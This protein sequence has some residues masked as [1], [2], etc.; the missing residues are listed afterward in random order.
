MLAGT[1][2]RGDACRA[3]IGFDI[4]GNIPAG[5]TIT[6][7]QLSLVLALVP[8]GDA[9]ARPIELHQV[10][11]NWG[12]GTSGQ[13][14]GPNGIGVGFMTPADGTTA[15]WS[16]RF[17]DTVPWANPG[18]EFAAAASS[19]ALVDAG[20]N[21]IFTWNS[22]QALVDDVQGWL[23]NPSSNFGWLLLGDESAAATGR[24]FYTRETSSSVVSPSLVVTYTPPAPTAV[25]LVLSAPASITA[26]SP[27]DV[28]VTVQDN[29]GIVI[30]GYTGTVS[31][32]SS[33]A[34]PAVLPAN[35]TFTS[36]DQGAH[37]FTAGV[38]LFAAGS[39]MLTVQDTANSATTGSAITAVIAAP[40]SQLL[41]T[42]PSIPPSGSP[43]DVTLAA[44]DSFGN[45]DMNYAGTV[46]WTSSDPD[47][48]VVLPANY[49]LQ[50]T[51]NGAVTF[52]SGITLI[53]LGDQTITATD[54]ASGITGSATVTVGPGA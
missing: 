31:F 50:S 18:G 10:L 41:V 38:T 13:D 32:S 6:S 42:A 19:T 44:I 9:V 14:T 28:T 17:Y 53:T 7:V 8:M 40:A 15:T 51:D 37:T 3:L 5:S 33:D 30:S 54:T 43:F 16:H 52:T 34:Y 45:V 1:T 46:T 39:Q 49:T 36:S 11:A 24:I 27:F 35:Y 4:A 2:G 47:P 12:E 20:S 26:G 22:T 21:T 25:Q 48:G 23:N 29:N